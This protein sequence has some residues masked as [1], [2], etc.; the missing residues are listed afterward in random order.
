MKDH[1]GGHKNTLY[2]DCSHGYTTITHW[3]IHLK[4]VNSDACK[5][6]LDICALKYYIARL[7]IWTQ[8]HLKMKP[9]LNTGE[10]RETGLSPGMHWA[11]IRDI[12]KGCW[13]GSWRLRGSAT[14]II[15]LSQSQNI[16][17]GLCVLFH[18][19]S[20]LGKQL[21][22]S[23][24]Y[25]AGEQSS[26]KWR[27]SLARVP[28]WLPN[29]HSLYSSTSPQGWCL[30]WEVEGRSPGWQCGDGGL[31]TRWGLVDGVWVMEC[32]TLGRNQYSSQGAPASSLESQLSEKQQFFFLNSSF[33][34]S[35]MW[36][37]HDALY[38]ISV[39]SEGWYHRINQWGCMILNFQSAKI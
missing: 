35:H 8:R 28:A 15:P 12:W 4:K 27:W 6:Y 39:W 29:S 37:Y 18:A 10:Q 1:S 13:P 7:P 22:Q 11:I 30:V 5:L 21:L 38:H 16:H 36:S 33:P 17:R 26:G 32:P 3:T 23:S 25:K 24:F 14:G 2:L 34:L 19:F 9:W 31:F 20:N